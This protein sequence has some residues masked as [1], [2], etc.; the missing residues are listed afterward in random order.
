MSRFVVDRLIVTEIDQIYPF[1]D[2]DAAFRKL[3]AGSHFGKIVFTI[4]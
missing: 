1:A 2:I 3:G 4:P